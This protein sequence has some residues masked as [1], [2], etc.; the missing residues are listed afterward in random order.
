ML[1][2]GV[3]D[4][5][6]LNAYWVPLNFQGSALLAIAVPAALLKIQG[7]ANHTQ[8][9]ATLA[10]MVAAISILVPPPVGA[11]S[12][13]MRR[14]RGVHRRAF[15]LL[16]TALN[17]AGLVWLAFTGSLLSFTAALVVAV[18]GQSIGTAA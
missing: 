2:P 3:R 1:S 5:S 16:G 9:F 7:G 12:D 8:V 11:I 6:L 13:R 14:H 15:I 4:Q 17:A 18:I 10:S